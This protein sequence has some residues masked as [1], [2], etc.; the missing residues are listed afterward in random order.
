MSQFRNRG[1]GG[2]SGG[3]NRGG[4]IRGGNTGRPGLLGAA[5]GI[6]GLLD[7]VTSHG[8]QQS[9][10]Q[11][12]QPSI[13]EQELSAYSGHDKKPGLLGNAPIKESTSWSREQKNIEYEQRQSYSDS[14][15]S[16]FSS[17]NQRQRSEERKQIIKQES[18]SSERLTPEVRRIMTTLGLTKG[19]MELLSRL[20]DDELSTSNLANLIQSIQNKKS[21][22]TTQEQ[23]HDLRQVIHRAS[24]HD[25]VQ[26]SFKSEY[27]ASSP[28]DLYDPSEPTE[29]VF[30]HRGQSGPYMKRERSPDAFSSFEQKWYS[31][32]VK[33]QNEHSESQAG[34]SI[35]RGSRGPASKSTSRWEK[36][37]HVHL[38]RRSL[39]PPRRM[40]PPLQRR[41]SP[42]MPRRPSL[43]PRRVSPP[44]LMSL[45]RRMSPPAR[46]L[47]S[48]LRGMSPQRLIPG[49][50]SGLLGDPLDPST[51]QL[52]YLASSLGGTR[53]PQSLQRRSPERHFSEPQR[54]LEPLQRG[55]S[56]PQPMV[57][58]NS[59]KQGKSIF[60]AQMHAVRELQSNSSKGARKFSQGGR[61]G[62][63]TKSVISPSTREE[64]QEEAAQMRARQ[65]RVLYLRYQA[66]RKGLIVEEDIIKLAQPFEKVTNILL[67]MPKAV[68]TGWFQAFVELA[69]Y[70][71]AAAMLEHYMLR[72]PT[73][74]KVQLQVQKSNHQT[75]KLREHQMN[76]DFSSMMKGPNRRRRPRSI[77]SDRSNNSFDKSK[78]SKPVSGSKFSNK[79]EKKTDTAKKIQPIKKKTKKT[80]VESE[81]NEEPN[82]N[83][84]S[85]KDEKEK[86]DSD[87]NK[88]VSKDKKPE[89]ATE[90][91]EAPSESF[92]RV[93]EVIEKMD[94]DVIVEVD[95]V[96][97]L[98]ED[99]K[100]K[101]AL[102]EK[103]RAK[104]AADLERLKIIQENIEQSSTMLEEVMKEI[105]E[106]SHKEIISESL[107][108]LADSLA[109]LKEVDGWQE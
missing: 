55:R 93:D 102:E 8:S 101:E 44:P 106:E 99:K 62:K 86:E 46:R 7:S 98:E 77:S 12:E 61:G 74:K 38:Q 27:R 48:S 73:V 16:E 34:S 21:R 69:E 81:S 67:V 92:R 3:R 52:D 70:D 25:N 78:K 108:Y 40:S 97:T 13:Y 1:R 49:L 84:T 18:R 14:H 79:N 105:K 50:R 17:Y 41:A 6:P 64:A 11:Y 15:E 39:S 91:S 88:T 68:S 4:K 58:T 89:S 66:G 95:E 28:D 42:I 37:E 5:P 85:S 72:P 94:Q 103:E 36:E 104:K 65:G 32:P 96:A 47:S 23:K 22:P 26:H 56:P 63:E 60:A 100:L 29:D 71:G 43:S 76:R 33:K 30:P 59:Q 53:E 83:G 57:H 90:S 75:L 51:K 107:E 31:D 54:F 45:T 20:P 109:Q 9:Y 80:P 19:D 87:S 35:L 82:T 2:F 24:S 10:S